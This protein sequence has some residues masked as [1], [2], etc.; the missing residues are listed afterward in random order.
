M[1]ADG[2]KKLLKRKKKLF[3][4]RRVRSF[5]ERENVDVK[6][7][8]KGRDT[9]KGSNVVN[10]NIEYSGDDIDIE[11]EFESTLRHKFA[12]F[13]SMIMQKPHNCLRRCSTHTVRKIFFN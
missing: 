5:S 2:D 7:R 9:D 6:V 3:Y 4:K 10:K 13:R 8:K 11:A 1:E 12:I